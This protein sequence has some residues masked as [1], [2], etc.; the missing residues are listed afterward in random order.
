MHD[1]IPLKLLPLGCTAT[2]A[3]IAGDTTAAHRL[4]ELG[5][6]D[7]AAVEMIQAGSSCIVRVNN[8]K[9]AFRSDDAMNVFVHESNPSGVSK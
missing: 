4:R 9:L 7:G 6:C 2:V 8:H 1:L 5:F 3:H